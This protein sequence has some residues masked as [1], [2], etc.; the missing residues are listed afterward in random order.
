MM[1]KKKPDSTMAE[2]PENGVL[3]CSL[4]IKGSVFNVKAVTVGVEKGGVEDD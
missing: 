1:N 4:Y 3:K 2:Y